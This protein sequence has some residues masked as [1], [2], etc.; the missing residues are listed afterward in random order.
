MHRYSAAFGATLGCMAA[1]YLSISSWAIPD[2]V[3]LVVFDV[4]ALTGFALL[5][6]KVFSA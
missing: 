6:R 3:A 4:L 5:G 1:P 2:L